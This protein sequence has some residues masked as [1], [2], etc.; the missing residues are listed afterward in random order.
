MT[1]KHSATNI[2][3]KERIEKLGGYVFQNR[4]YGAL[5]VARSLG[6]AEYKKPTAGMVYFLLVTMKIFILG[7]QNV[8]RTKLYLL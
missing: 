7:Y 5:S 2:Q 1:V 8:I 6:D 4:V 3:E